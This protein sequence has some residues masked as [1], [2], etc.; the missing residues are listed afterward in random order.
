MM[1]EWV[2]RKLEQIDELYPPERINRSI[3]RWRRMWRGE[4][5]LDRYPYSYAQFL[6]I[7]YNDVHTPEERLRVSLD[8]IILLGGLLGDNIPSIFPGCKQSTIPTM[9]GSK[10]I[11]K[12]TDYTCEHIIHSY[13]D[14]DR[15]P[16][17]SVGPGTVAYEWLEMQKYMLEETEGRIPI[18]VTDMQG[19]V[20][21]AGQLWGYDDLFV[22][23]Y[24]EPEYYHKIL[25]RVTQAFILF[26][27]AQKDLLGKCF[28]PTH[29]FGWSWVPEDMGASI[30]TDSI[31]MVSPKFFDDFFK[32]YIEEIGKVFGNISLHSC[33]DFTSVFNNLTAIPYLK[34][35][36]AG[37]MTVEQL[38]KAGLDSRT[39][40]I[41]L[42][43]VENAGTMFSLIKQNSLR[44]DLTFLGD[45]GMWPSIDGRIIQP[46]EMT[47]PLWDELRRK[48]EKINM[49][50]AECA[51]TFKI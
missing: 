48:D 27:K 12:G 8:E 24:E 20:D 5:P 50:A 47:E 33:G 44:V 26:W 35:V 40:A 1:K 18:H 30:S 16:E 17:P 21:V 22:A 23:A 10:E 36:N 6:F 32:P 28:V 13:E 45:L 9:F 31:V 37:Q 4:K 2:K 38:V 3:E 25:A 39:V 51:N 42:S 7:Y 19:P 14:I 11:I 34:A 29:L 43:D 46:D 49:Y 41:A 15:L